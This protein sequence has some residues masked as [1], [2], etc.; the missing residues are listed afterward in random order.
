[1][2]LLP[3]LSLGAFFFSLTLA[4][5]VGMFNY[6]LRIPPIEHNLSALDLL[7]LF[8]LMHYTYF[9]SF[10]FTSN[11]NSDRLDFVIFSSTL[12]NSQES[13]VL[14]HPC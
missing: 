14:S 10:T 8:F 6:D 2:A 1:M 13:R 3:H 9:S 12:N 4:V 7:L 11:F 5:G